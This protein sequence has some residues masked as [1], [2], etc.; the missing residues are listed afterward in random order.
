MNPKYDILIIGSGLGGLVTGNILGKKG[1]K[2]GIL[3]K[4]SFAG[5]CLQSFKKDGVL[6]DTGIHYVGGFGEG[7]VLNKIYSYLD[8]LPALKLR[9]MD[10]EGYDRFR[11]GK[12]EYAYPIG[13]D[14]FKS[15]LLSYFPQEES[16]ID[17]YIDTV[18]KITRSVSLYNLE[19]VQFDMEAFYSKF[20]YGN[21]WEFICSLSENNQ[22]RQF[23]AGP[24]SLYAGTPESAFMYIHALI[25]N[26]YV[27]G[28]YRFVDGTSQIT[29]Q[30]L[31]KFSS[32]GGELILNQKAAKFRFDDHKIC[33]VLTE[34][35]HEFFGENIISDIHPYYTM[36]MIEG[37]K[38]RESYRKRIQSLKNTISTFSLFVV[39]EDGK[40]PYMNSNYYYCPKGNVW[41]ASNCSVENFPEGFGLYPVADSVDE[42]FTRGFSVLTFMDYAEVEK[43]ENTTL[44]KRGKEYD[45]FKEAKALK[46]LDKLEEA[47]PGIRKNIKSYTASTPLTLRDYTGTYRGA[48]YGIVRDCRNPLESMLFPRTKIPNL[49]LTGQN[50]NM[51]GFMGVSAGALLTCA[52]FTDLNLLLNEING[53]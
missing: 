28:A 7:Q 29:E 50:L 8:V 9:E 1:Y 44:E 32:Y 4:N 6:F 52:E 20:N 16:A 37:G 3:E 17:K 19:P 42:E 51:H 46:V 24:N 2:V 31:K 35:Q 49:Y 48:T 36:E 22:L 43:W 34:D 30:L 12:E 13:Y 11:I 14:K 53:V 41:G 27:E 10:R 23:L 26:H 15:Q 38:V 5:G 45:A 18:R 21:A 47:F 39:L 40:V 33:S 25:T